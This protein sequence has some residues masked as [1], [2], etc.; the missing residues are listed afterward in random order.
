MKAAP[1]FYRASIA[2]PSLKAMR[3]MARSLF[4]FRNKIVAVIATVC[5]RLLAVQH[6][7]LK[8]NKRFVIALRY[9]CD[10]CEIMIGV[11]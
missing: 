7:V 8:A 4:V 6:A 9:K 3:V 5:Q 10:S 2:F 1:A 11:P